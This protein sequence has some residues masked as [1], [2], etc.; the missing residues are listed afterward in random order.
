MKRLL[1]MVMFVVGLLTS[2]AAYA[3]PLCGLRI[4]C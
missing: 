3:V 1:L 4:V 2:G